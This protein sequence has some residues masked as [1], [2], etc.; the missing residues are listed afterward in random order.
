MKELEKE[1]NKSAS[2]N[3]TLGF[4]LISLIMILFFVGAVYWITNAFGN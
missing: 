2:E 4:I 1:K 3:G